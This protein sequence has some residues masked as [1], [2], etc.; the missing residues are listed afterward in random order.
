[1]HSKKISE[2]FFS[3]L[4]KSLALFGYNGTGYI[5]QVWKHQHPSFWPKTLRVTL[6]MSSKFWIHYYST[7]IALTILFSWDAKH[8]FLLELSNRDKS[9]FF[10]ILV[11][12]F[13]LHTCCNFKNK[14]TD[15]SVCAFCSFLPFYSHFLFSKLCFWLAPTS[16]LI[17][18]FWVLYRVSYIILC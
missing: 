8:I 6:C 12:A 18:E 13:M 7:L 10:T 4:Q 14:I 9:F 11:C 3:S 1:M 17:A 5:N 2:T 16:I 15:L